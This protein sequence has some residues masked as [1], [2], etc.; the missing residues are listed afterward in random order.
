MNNTE[1]KMSGMR[2]KNTDEYRK[3]QAEKV[4]ADVEAYIAAGKPITWIPNGVSGDEKLSLTE[5]QRRAA[6]GLR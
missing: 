1:S 4:S 2:R 6:L 3:S 5:T